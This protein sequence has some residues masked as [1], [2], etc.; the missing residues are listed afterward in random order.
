M[1]NYADPSTPPNS[2]GL[3]NVGHVGGVGSTVTLPGGV[4]TGLTSDEMRRWYLNQ[5]P[6]AGFYSFLGAHGLAGGVTPQEK[7]AQG[8]FN[9]T[10][11]NYLAHAAENPD[12]GFYDYLEQQNPDLNAGFANQSPT[13]RGDFSSR[14]Y[15]PR[16]RWVNA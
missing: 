14:T 2:I 6:T 15:Q 13:Q 12:L 10:F 7:F 5:D 1:A 11:N 4:P 16:G 3:P 8:Q 9:T